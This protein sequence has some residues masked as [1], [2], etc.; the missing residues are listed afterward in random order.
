M[1]IPQGADNFDHAAMCTRAG[2][3]VT[4]LP[5]H[6]D[7]TSVANA[8]RQVLHEPGYADAAR[9]TADEID[10]MPGPDSVAEALR[11][12]ARTRTLDLR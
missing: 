3:A 5:G 7:P 6:V 10:A 1:I 2:T 9:T 8:V 4:I 12:Y 11:A